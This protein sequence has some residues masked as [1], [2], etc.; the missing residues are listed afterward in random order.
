MSLR[1]IR[2]GKAG[3]LILEALGAAAA[4]VAALAGYVLWRIEQGPTEIGLLAR[5]SEF[6]VERALPPRNSAKVRRA[7][8]SRDRAASAYVVTLEDVSIA[9][10]GKT[11]VA[12]LSRIVLTFAP[13]DL[14]RGRIGP[15]AIAIEEPF[16]RIVR[17][18][19]RKLSLDYQEGAAPGA[20]GRSVFRM[21][22]GDRWRGAFERAEL[23]GAKIQF[24]DVASGRAWRATDAAA[25]IRRVKGGYEARI[26]GAF[27]INGAPAALR[28]EA[29][30]SEAT[31]LVT[32]K[33]DVK[34]APVGDILDMF[35][36]EQAAIL[37]APVSGKA[38]VTLTKSGEVVA[39]SVSGRASAGE[40]FF[41]GRRIPVTYAA[42]SAKFDPK[43]NR[44]D[45]SD[46]AFDADGSRGAFKGVVGLKFRGEERM[47]ATISVDAVG[48]EMTLDAKGFWE[49]PL[50][51][52]RLAFSGVFDVQESAFDVERLSVQT[53]GV[54]IAGAV[55]Y[56]PASD[57]QV[58]KRSGASPAHRDGAQRSPAIKADISVDGSLDPQRIVAGWPRKSAAEARAFVATRIPVARVENVE[59]KLDLKEG[60]LVKGRG[61]PD[62]ALHLSFDI[63]GATAIYAPTMT[64]VTGASGKAVLTGDSFRVDVPAARIGSIDL[65]NGVVHFTSL[66]RGAPV[67]YRFSGKSGAR[68]IMT[69]LNQPP[70]SFLKASRLEPQRFSGDA[71]FDIDIMRPNRR[72]VAR[73]EYAVEGVAAFRNV[74][75]AELY[76]GADFAQG[77]GTVRLK[78]RTMTVSA[79]AEIGGAPI[80]LDW[81]ER[82]FSEGKGS[83]FTLSGVVDSATGDVFGVPS[84]QLFRGP[85]AFRAVAE[86]NPAK[87]RSV[88]LTADFTN[89]SMVFG[90]FGWAKP[91]GAPA[92]ATFDIALPETGA[93]LRS[94][95]LT[96]AGVAIEG[97]GAFAPDGKLLEARFP[98][99][100]LDGAADLAVTARRG[101]AGVFMLDMDARYLN[102]A[103]LIESLVDQQGRKKDDPGPSLGVSGR[104]ARFDARAGAAYRDVNLFLRQTRGIVDDLS[105]TAKTPSGAPLTI[106][107]VESEQSH[108]RRF[109]AQSDDVGALLSGIFGVTSIRNGAGVL[110]IDMAELNADVPRLAGDFS[111]ANIRVVEAPLLARVFAAG[112]L[113]GLVDLL[114]GG[115]I[116][117][118]RASGEF[119]F[120]KGQLTVENARASGPSVGITAQG[121]M[122]SGGGPVELKGAVAPAYQINSFLGKAPLVGDLLVGR[123]G[124]GVVALSYDVKGRSDAPL[125]TV[126]PLSALA[127]G[128]LRRIFDVDAPAAAQATPQ[129]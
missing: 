103:P 125:V 54:E 85:V 35:Y 39:S 55:S 71:R 80:K 58:S 50:V 98:V 93:A 7:I 72:D 107:T 40:L 49:T 62:E 13:E 60:A 64:P 46:F 43:T 3:I 65:T 6:A 96:G 84:R 52:E 117:I 56:R 129:P 57:K 78:G 76:R 63:A 68:E 16:L 10:K 15:R 24:A 37:A 59:L 99:F 31:G 119:E 48:R 51:V 116:E 106:R 9:G 36:G 11:R 83:H 118:V 1:K 41:R 29:A 21:L 4:V 14:L 33:M 69:L 26:D 88:A 86:G 77:A 74:T 108:A 101:E 28:A 17:G 2:A 102:A 87:I 18:R 70:L 122:T 73:N 66:K 8:V 114:N 111:A 127:P 27:D 128:F 5:A 109:E 121:T 126:D 53:L 100:K 105:L 94:F 67:H 95:K 47:P 90:M 113:N 89:A 123:K 92:T 44:F 124:E 81:T 34:D 61:L 22:T 38:S 30:F 115:G 20:P 79:D 104:I 75:I 112:S 25:S 45:V 12:D 97:S 42:L 91:A 32:A 110:H 82:F 23:K 120:Y 19:D